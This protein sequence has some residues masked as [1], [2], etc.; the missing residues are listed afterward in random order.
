MNGALAPNS[1]LE[2]SNSFITPWIHPL[3]DSNFDDR[4]GCPKTT[5]RPAAARWIVANQARCASGHRAARSA[6]VELARTADLVLGSDTISF[7]CAIQPTVRASAKIAVNSGTGCRWLLHDARVVVDVRVQL[8]RHEVVVLERDL[9]E[10][11]REL[12]QRVVVQPEHGED[13]VQVSRISFARG[14][15]SCT[16]GGRSPSASLRVLVL[17]LGDELADP[18]RAACAWMS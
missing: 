18:G 11:H 14:S 3:P 16:R 13:L 15:C 8:A 12:E 2:D 5:G 7:S 9:L 6:R 4:G 10:R 17:H 1:V